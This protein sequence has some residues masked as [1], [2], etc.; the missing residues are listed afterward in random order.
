MPKFTFLPTRIKGLCR[1]RPFFTQ[2]ARGYFLKSFERDAFRAQGIDMDIQESFETWSRK[3]VLRG[4]HF[5]S[6]APQAKLIRAL[7]GRIFDVTVDLRRGSDTFGQWEGFMLDD[8]ERC[9]LYI[10]P[11]FA[12]GFLV[13]SEKAQVSYQCAGAYLAREDTGV[14]WNDPDICVQWPLHLVDGIVLSPRDQSLPSLRECIRAQRIP[15]EEE[16]TR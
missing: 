15:N 10:P 11:G 9:A 5:Q 4:L 13:V 12:H 1:V 2:D 6:K 14:V 3:G 7:Q 16:A 8:E